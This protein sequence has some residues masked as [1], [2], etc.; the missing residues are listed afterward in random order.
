MHNMVNYSKVINNIY[1]VT[2][3]SSTFKEQAK[4]LLETNTINIDLINL[5]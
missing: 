3:L 4:I 1:F 5:D 2:D